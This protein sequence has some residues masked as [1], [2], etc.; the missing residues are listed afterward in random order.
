MG[1]TSLGKRPIR[2]THPIV[3]NIWPDDQTLKKPLVF[4]GID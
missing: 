2:E 1:S 4:W 3:K